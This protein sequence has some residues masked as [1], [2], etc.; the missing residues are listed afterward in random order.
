[1]EEGGGVALGRCRKQRYALI[2][3]LNIFNYQQWF[4]GVT[5]VVPDN[6]KPDEASGGLDDGAAHGSLPGRK[7]EID[8]LRLLLV[9]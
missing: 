8:R 7:M 9:V 2:L 5:I 3:G 1:M 6:P 4:L